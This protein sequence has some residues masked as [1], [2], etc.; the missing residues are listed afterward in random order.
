[1]G[2]SLLNVMGPIMVG[3]S[4]S[5]TAGAVRL[6]N[7]A[8]RIGGENFKKVDF[9]LHGSFART[10]KGHG[11][12]KALLGGVMGL[13]PSDEAIRDSFTIAK[14]QGIEFYFHTADLGNVH[15]NTVRIMMTRGNSTSSEMTGSSIG[16][17]DVVVISV[18][19]MKL[20][21]TGKYPTIITVHKDQPGI[22]A[23][24]TSILSKHAINIAFLRVFRQVRGQEATMV[25]ETDQVIGNHVL[26][27]L[28]NVFDINK[29]LFIDTP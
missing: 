29:I 21:F 2:T 19:Q 13:L 24:V 17:G 26:Q 3:P 14:K 22:V 11:T 7:I 25:I 1:M 10:F 5:H 20:E 8:R 6:G 28:Q 23:R 4:S 18:N 27:E 12:D 16:G 15:P 9:Y